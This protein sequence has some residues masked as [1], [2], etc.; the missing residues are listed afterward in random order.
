M[1]QK[2]QTPGGA[3]LIV[4]QRSAV[5]RIEI[6]RRDIGEC[7]QAQEDAVHALALAEDAKLEA[8]GWEQPFYAGMTVW[9]VSTTTPRVAEVLE[10]LYAIESQP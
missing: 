3:R 2:R 1:G 6:D 5:T 4:D 9:L 7:T 10:R 8:I